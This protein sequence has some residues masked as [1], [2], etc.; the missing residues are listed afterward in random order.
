MYL[1][2]WRCSLRAHLQCLR[3]VCSAQDGM[4]CS[5]LRSG[6]VCKYHYN[7]KHWIAYLL[8]C[9]IYYLLLDRIQVSENVSAINFQG[10]HL[11]STLQF[12]RRVLTRET[13]CSQSNCRASTESKVIR[14][15]IFSQKRLY[16]F[17]CLLL[18]GGQTVDLS[19]N[20]R[21]C[22]RKSVKRAIEC[23]ILQ[24]CSSSGSRVMCR[25]V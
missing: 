13:R 25:F 14:E 15:N 21:T 2:G 10:D 6:Q 18:S 22:Q 17:F 4:Q 5:M 12:I 20:L 8:F 19:S 7:T 1:T 9:Y 23:A 3:T 16:F 11:R 24:C